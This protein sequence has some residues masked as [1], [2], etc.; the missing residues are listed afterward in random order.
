M[1][2]GS[3]DKR[4]LYKYNIEVLNKEFDTGIIKGY[5][6]DLDETCYTIKDNAHFEFYAKK[7]RDNISRSL[8]KD[9]DRIYDR[10][11]SGKTPARIG[12][13]Y[14]RNKE[15]FIEFDLQSGRGVS[16]KYVIDWSGKR[17][18]Y[19]NH[20]EKKGIERF[21]RASI[22]PISDSWGL[23]AVAAYKCGI[24][25]EKREEAHTLTKDELRK[26]KFEFV[27]ADNLAR[28]LDVCRSRNI[29]LAVSSN[30]KEQENLEGVLSMLGVQDKFDYK[31]CDAQKLESPRSL[32]E[33]VSRN[34]Q[35]PDNNICYV[36]NNVLNDL[37]PGKRRGSQTIL[38]ETDKGQKLD[39]VDIVVPSF[40]S[41]INF[42]LENVFR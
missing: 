22:F 36:G 7:L 40:G 17:S 30:T 12:R 34:L 33:D 19:S 37:R 41:W 18:G 8:R 29:K 35:L 42:C 5:G 1:V 31:R 32:F 27:P 39:G 14:D 28:F 24:A 20:Y 38:I 4:V 6:L 13:A 3:W 16:I 11:K 15:V 10:I 26:G 9:F 2:G 23:A 25:P 21:D